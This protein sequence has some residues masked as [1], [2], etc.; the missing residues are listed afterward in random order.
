MLMKWVE[1]LSSNF[2]VLLRIYELFIRLRRKNDP[3]KVI[4]D[5]K[6]GGMNIGRSV[7]I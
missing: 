4:S 1:V 7:K 3:K 2:W 6:K 5:P